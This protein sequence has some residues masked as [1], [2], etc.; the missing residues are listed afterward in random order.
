MRAKLKQALIDKAKVS[1]GANNNM[2]QG[3]Y[4]DDFAHFDQSPGNLDVLLTGSGVTAG[5]VVNE[6]NSGSRF[7]NR[8]TVDLTGV[9]KGRGQGPFGN[10]DHPQD[11]ILAVKLPNP[12][13]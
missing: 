3:P 7:P 9:N 4:S 2:V 8:R 13:V 5:M 1:V 11:T 10:S 12:F 6:E